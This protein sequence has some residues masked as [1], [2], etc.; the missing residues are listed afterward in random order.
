MTVNIDHWLNLHPGSRIEG[1]VVTNLEGQIGRAETGE[2]ACG[3]HYRP[4]RRSQAG[5]WTCPITGCITR[6]ET[7]PAS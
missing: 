1:R 5:N 4:L 6:I 3:I 7:R 2:F